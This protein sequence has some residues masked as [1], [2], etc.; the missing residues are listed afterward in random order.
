MSRADVDWARTERVGE[1]DA[2][3]AATDA[4]AHE[5]AD[6]LII[7]AARG[8]RGRTRGRW[9][10]GLG[11]GLHRRSVWAWC[12]RP[13]GWSSRA[14]EGRHGFLLGR[15]PR[16]NPMRLCR[17]RDGKCSKCERNGAHDSAEHGSCFEWSRLICPPK[18]LGVMPRSS[19]Q[20][21]R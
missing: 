3:A 9:R 15:G 2:H 12:D 1:M 19:D 14:G 21:W 4:G 17:C 6:G 11:R 20:E 10:S 5:H 13:R 7:K 16:R 18:Y 8:R